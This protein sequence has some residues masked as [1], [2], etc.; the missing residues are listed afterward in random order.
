MVLA[1]FEKSGKGHLFI[2]I[3]DSITNDFDHSVL[4]K[5]LISLIN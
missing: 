4:I 5:Y 1:S 2:M 3:A